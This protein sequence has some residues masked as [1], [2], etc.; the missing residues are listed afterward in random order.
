MSTGNMPD[1]T[2]QDG[3]D[4]LGGEYADAFVPSFVG[5]M[6][7]HCYGPHLPSRGKGSV[8]LLPVGRHAVRIAVADRALSLGQTRLESH[9]RST[10]TP[11]FAARAMSASG[12]SFT[13][14][15]LIIMFWDVVRKALTRTARLEP[16]QHVYFTHEGNRGLPG[17]KTSVPDSILTMRMGGENYRFLWMEVCKSETPHHVFSKVSN[18][19]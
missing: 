9:L 8:P 15:D 13:H 5:Q 2:P 16:R 11:T 17:S 12:P 10:P 6:L 1:M 14:E 18:V 7:P 4:C 19:R 3:A